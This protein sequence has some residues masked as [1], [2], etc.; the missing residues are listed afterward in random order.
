MKKQ[1]EILSKQ[2]ANG[3]KR[4]V[5]RRGFAGSNFCHLKSKKEGIG[6]TIGC[7]TPEARDLLQNIMDEWEKHLKELKKVHGKNYEPE[8]YGFA[9]WLVRWSGLVQPS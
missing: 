7:I 8:Y 3:T 2:K 4:C 5:K 6:I 1:K 9:Y